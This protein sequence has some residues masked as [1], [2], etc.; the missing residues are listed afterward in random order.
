MRGS[1][2]WRRQSGPDRLGSLAAPGAPIPA[3]VAGTSSLTGTWV[4]V[5]AKI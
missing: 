1:P 2:D 5:T 4:A 3:P